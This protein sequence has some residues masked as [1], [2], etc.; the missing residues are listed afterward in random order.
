MKIKITLIA[1]FA[2]MIIPVCL[3]AVSNAA[4]IFL[5][6]EPGSRS[7]GM[8]HAYVAQVDDAYA[9]WWNPGA[10]AFNR[11]TQI[12]G[13]HSNWFGDVFDDMYYEYL[14]WNQYIQDVGN[15]GINLTYM[16]YGEQQYT[17]ETNEEEGTFTSFDFALGASY[18]SQIAEDKGVG[19]TFK[20]IYSS[21]GPGQGN[22]DTSKGTGLSYAFDFGYQ[23]KG[24][25]FGQALVSPYNGFVYLYN[26]VTGMLGGNTLGRS[27]FSA[28]VN[29]LDFG[30]NLQNVGPNIVYMDEDQ[31]DPLPMTF[32]MGYSYRIFDSQYSK[33]TFNTDMSKILANDDPVIKR[34]FT[35]WTDDFNTRTDEN[36]E[37]IDDFSSFNNFINSVEVKEIIFGFGAEYVYLDLLSVR[38]GYVMDRAGEIEGLSAGIGIHKTFSN[39]Y[40]FGV[41]FAMQPAGG[42]TDYN[43]TYSLKLEF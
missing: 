41:D 34:L 24:V 42:L 12:A 39:K 35:A 32:R 26:G 36:G 25:D 7:G 20:F 2:V 23:G 31:S 30:V 3:S 38:A 9:G 21:L 27:E 16:T 18:A 29:R 28:P 10:M 11:K 1:L 5:T 43:K 19:V 40:K 17:T 22:T 14:G 37:E 13:I 33:L 15:V 4:P 6:I 8:G